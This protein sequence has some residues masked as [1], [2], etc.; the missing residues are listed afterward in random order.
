MAQNYDFELPG[1]PSIYQDA[2]PRNFKVYFSEPE[3]GTNEETGL[4]LLVPGYGGHSQSN[5]Y[6]KMRSEFADKHNLI[7]IQC[8]YFG[9][10]FMQTN[11]ALTS[12]EDFNAYFR[13]WIEQVR[14]KGIHGEVSI[15]IEEKLGESK[16]N[17]NDMSI[18]QAVDNI[19]AVIAVSEIL[20]D[21][22]LRFNAKRVISYGHS[23]G[24]YLC[25]LANALAPGLFSLIIDNSA[26]ISPYYFDLR[27]KVSRKVGQVTGTILNTYIA[28]WIVDREL[29][30]LKNVYRQIRPKS[31]RIISYQGALDSIVAADEKDRFC[32]NIGAE[33]HLIQDADVDGRMFKSTN[34]GIGADFLLLFDHVLDGVSFSPGSDEIRINDVQITTK[35]GVYSLS[36]A[37]K[38]PMVGCS[39]KIIMEG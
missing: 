10:E 7:V 30:D 14:E 26:Y 28:G 6:K 5:V 9:H 24:A 29:A 12:D 1:H 33:Y 18:M 23:H 3:G 36:Y 4:C 2:A 8:D 15:D 32:R 11:P 22:G 39:K 19:S 31:A 21:N 37:N 25:L 35:S 17:F 13:K 34:H 20:K 27:R 16:G 38:M